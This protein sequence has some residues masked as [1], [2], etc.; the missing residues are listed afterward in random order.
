MTAHHTE[1]YNKKTL[2]TVISPQLSHIS[3]EKLSQTSNVTRDSPVCQ[4]SIISDSVAFPPISDVN[5]NSL[6]TPDEVLNQHSK[7]MKKRKEVAVRCFE[8]APV[9]SCCSKGGEE[10]YES[11]SP[12]VNPIASHGTN[13]TSCAHLS[14][15]DEIKNKTAKHNFPSTCRLKVVQTSCVSDSHK[16]YSSEQQQQNVNLKTIPI[17]TEQQEINKPAFNKED[18]TMNHEP[19]SFMSSLKDN[20]KPSFIRKDER[21]QKCYKTNECV[22]SSSVTMQPERTELSENSVEVNSN[23]GEDEIPS[24]IKTSL[25]R[26][27]ELSRRP[28][29]LTEHNSEDSAEFKK[30]KEVGVTEVALFEEPKELLHKP[31]EITEVSFS[32]NVRSSV[33]FQKDTSKKLTAGS[34]PE[35]RSTTQ[36]KKNMGSTKVIMLHKTEE[37]RNRPPEQVTLSDTQNNVYS[38]SDIIE[39]QQATVSTVTVRRLCKGTRNLG[40]ADASVSK[41]NFSLIS[42]PQE[43][44]LISDIKANAAEKS[45]TSLYKCQE[46]DKCLALENTAKND[47]KIAENQQ[48]AKYKTPFKGV[49]KRLSSKDVS[50]SCSG[51]ILLNTSDSAKADTRNTSSKKMVDILHEPYKDNDILKLKNNTL[52]NLDFIEDKQAS[53]SRKIL[54]RSKRLLN[55]KQTEV[56]L[57][58]N[59]AMDKSE[60]RE[61]LKPQT[62][63]DVAV[64]LKRVCDKPQEHAGSLEINMQNNSGFVEDDTDAS[65]RNTETLKT[66]K[67]KE[68]MGSCAVNNFDTLAKPVGVRTRAFTRKSQEQIDI[69]QNNA[70]HN[71]AFVECRKTAYC[72]N[73][74]DGKVRLNN[75]QPQEVR[76]CALHP[77][78]LSKPTVNRSKVSGKPNEEFETLKNNPQNVTE[79]KETLS[80]RKITEKLTEPHKQQQE[81]VGRV[82]NKSDS[83]AEPKVEKSRKPCKKLEQV[84][85]LKNN[86]QSESDFVEEKKTASSKKRT[87][88]SKTLHNR[89]QEEVISSSV[90]NFCSLT[91]PTAGKSTRLGVKRQEEPEAGKQ[92]RTVDYQAHSEF[93]MMPTARKLH[94]AGKTLGK[95]HSKTD[96]TSEHYTKQPHNDRIDSKDSRG[97]N[98]LTNNDPSSRGSHDSSEYRMLSSLCD[99]A[100]TS[101]IQKHQKTISKNDSS[102]GGNSCNADAGISRGVSRMETEKNVEKCVQGSCVTRKPNRSGF[103][104][105]MLQQLIND[106]NSDTEPSYKDTRSQDLE[107]ITNPSAD[108]IQQILK[109]CD[110]NEGDDNHEGVL[111]GEAADVNGKNKKLSLNV[112][113]HKH[114]KSPLLSHTVFVDLQNVD[115]NTPK[116]KNEELKLCENSKTKYALNSGSIKEL[117]DPNNVKSHNLKKKYSDPNAGNFKQLDGLALTNKDLSSE[118]LDQVSKTQEKSSDS[119]K[120]PSRKRRLYSLPHSPEV[121]ELQNCDDASSIQ[122]VAVT[123]LSRG[124]KRSRKNNVSEPQTKKSRGGGNKQRKKKEVTSG[125]SEGEHLGVN[126]SS[127]GGFSQERQLDASKS[128]QLSMKSFSGRWHNKYLEDVTKRKMEKNYKEKVQQP[129][130][131]SVYS[132]LET[133]S[134]SVISWMENT[135]PK[136]SEFVQKPKVTYE[137]KRRSMFP[138]KQKLKQVLLPK[139]LS[140][141]PSRPRKENGN[142]RPKIEKSTLRKANTEK[143]ISRGKKSSKDPSVETFVSRA[144]ENRLPE[145]DVFRSNENDKFDE[146]LPVEINILPCHDV[147]TTSFS[148]TLPS[149][150]TEPENSIQSKTTSVRKKELLND[151]IVKK[152]NIDNAD[153]STGNRKERLHQNDINLFS[154]SSVK[155]AGNSEIIASSRN[156]SK[157]ACM[158]KFVDHDIIR[159]EYGSNDKREVPYRTADSKMRT[160][161]A[162]EESNKCFYDPFLGAE[163]RNAGV[164]EN[165]YKRR[166]GSEPSD[167]IVEMHS[168]HKG[169]GCSQYDPST[170]DSPTNIQLN[171]TSEQNDVIESSL[172]AAEIDICPKS[173]Q[174]NSGSSSDTSAVCCED[175]FEEF[176]K[177]FLESSEKD[178]NLYGHLECNNMTTKKDMTEV[179]KTGREMVCG[180]KTD[181]VISNAPFLLRGSGDDD[182]KDCEE[183]NRPINVPCPAIE[184]EQPSVP[185]LH[186]FCV[187]NDNSLNSDSSLSPFNPIFASSF[188]KGD[189]H[190][191]N[192]AI[193]KRAEG[194]VSP[195]IKRCQKSKDHTNDSF[196]KSDR[197]SFCPNIGSLYSERFQ[198]HLGQINDMSVSK[199]NEQP[200]SPITGLSYSKRGQKPLS[201]HLVRISPIPIPSLP[202]EAEMADVP[203]SSL[204]LCKRQEQYNRE[205][206]EDDTVLPQQLPAAEDLNEV[207]VQS[208]GFKQNAKRVSK[209]KTKNKENIEPTVVTKQKEKFKKRNTSFDLANDGTSSRDDRTMTIQ[210]TIEAG[211]K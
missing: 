120:T 58:E 77:D 200:L 33:E 4:T 45:G 31:A 124:R 67:Q 166:A 9:A 17:T 81:I 142:T 99:T 195:N 65:F 206:L 85:S 193:L 32:D 74:I 52:N 97:S 160:N 171:F 61:K 30:V 173:S 155:D 140:G 23:L 29:E 5:G 184:V 18:K 144:V 38:Y 154:V 91:K 146:V 172:P 113:S 78:L 125:C 115:E 135:K 42:D 76:D 70:Q 176:C 82:V 43:G 69:L 93:S 51:N 100:C 7:Q 153:K 34:V 98:I 127:F 174:N 157:L 101:D 148:R 86:T 167:E 202:T 149:L 60:S 108:K 159:Q 207:G 138:G 10:N 132:D 203:F 185:S 143:R 35:S 50:P 110:S 158:K 37:I 156:F 6:N 47:S 162:S 168:N 15:V 12:I 128:T 208:F 111:L 119:I 21:K 136:R 75:V 133:D 145:V 48:V 72:R 190:S 104:S 122:Y 165:V 204:S 188:L 27:N 116:S 59:C 53:S 3:E 88:T 197:Q 205:V 150:I 102:V 28:R 13:M 80:S 25:G 161:V 123:R 24:S 22:K 178:I 194:P 92:E 96:A 103:D 118:A 131:N 141:Q 129:M 8:S 11:A 20:I 170:F 199:G 117:D 175:D 14:G 94:D 126:V 147:T 40:Y 121:N 62:R 87:K 84:E 201:P 63:R 187:E 130:Y 71:S 39:I 151:K 26:Q 66:L 107:I 109:D 90:S 16:L 137:K 105:S 95:V 191:L 179:Q 1:K 181:K 163:K 56:S 180:K 210:K 177:Q 134:D 182:T 112:L 192:T 169:T 36:N 2:F 209:N 189:G 49:S 183:E 73:N 19:H 186:S 79:H 164:N 41:D 55:K 89:Q 54:S 196:S 68:K 44:K 211:G 198:K 46:Q 57:S 106:W 64:S 114:S 83:A 139:Q 152:R